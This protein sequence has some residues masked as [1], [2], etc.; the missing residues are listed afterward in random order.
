MA[1]KSTNG[2][3]G[4]KYDVLSNLGNNLTN[5]GLVAMQGQKSSANEQENIV[6]ETSKSNK[7]VDKHGKGPLPNTQLE[8]N[9]IMQSLTN[10][11]GK[12]KRAT[13][14]VLR[15]PLSLYLFV[16]CMERLSHII[17]DACSEG[18]WNPIQFRN[19]GLNWSHSFF[20]DDLVLF[21]ESSM[22]QIQSI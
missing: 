4:S 14:P 6:V 18:Y 10:Y 15:D 5:S 1:T 21:G 19:G 17:K 2:S 3:N 7:G 22:R 11:R 9:R 12:N 13:P 16:L 20:A 8:M